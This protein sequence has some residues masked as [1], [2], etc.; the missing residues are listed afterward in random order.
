MA[1]RHREARD[2]DWWSANAG[3]AGVELEVQGGE[4]CSAENAPFHLCLAPNVLMLQ[5]VL[6]ILSHQH[7]RSDGL[8]TNIQVN[9][10]ETDTYL[11]DKE[12]NAT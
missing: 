9:K 4:N 1:A 3:T 5:G 12:N 11:C 8:Q 6:Q 10:M 2:A 7:G